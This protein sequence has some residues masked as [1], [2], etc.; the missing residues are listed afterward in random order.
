[1]A[2]SNSTPV[3]QCSKCFETKPVSEF[4]KAPGCKD[5]LRGE[6]KQCTRVAQDAYKVLNNA[7]I[8]VQ[9]AGYIKANPEKIKAQRKACYESHK[10]DVLEK[11]AIYYVENKEA[12]RE[13]QKVY[14]QNNA[15]TIKTYR[16]ENSHKQKESQKIW[17]SVNQDYVRAYRVAYW[18][19]NKKGLIAKKAI[20]R[21]KNG[22]ELRRKEREKYKETYDPDH[23]WAKLNPEKNRKNAAAWRAANPELRIIWEHNRRARKRASGG[24]LSAGLSEKLFRLQK[25][26]CSCCRLP[27]GSDYHLDHIMPLALGGSNTDG[28]MQLL[29]AE[30]NLKK[31]AK[32]PIDYMQSRGFL[33]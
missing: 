17:R 29:R 4:Y 18:A 24:E 32:H 27:L 9:K 13:K 33:L 1:M 26:K 31:N 30:C 25:G 20:Y 21:E 5:G 12:I 11:C 7:K 19:K 2:D 28:N 8:R 15:E 16:E 10:K 14:R 3:K 22:D 6:C 23:A